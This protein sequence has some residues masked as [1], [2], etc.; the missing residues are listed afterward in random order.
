MK[1]R[2]SALFDTLTSMSLMNYI[3]TPQKDLKTEWPSYPVAFFALMVML[4]CIIPLVII[5]VWAVVYTSI[6]FP[7]MRIPPVRRRDYLV[8]DR[9]KLRKLA[10]IQRFGCLYCSYANGVTAW[11]KAVANMTEL[12]TCAIRHS[13]ERKGQE[14]QK[15]FYPYNKFQ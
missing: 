2:A 7:L 11:C 3:V 6:F 14:H 5:D 10:P 12:Y 1:G 9:A 4:T 13:L 8:F 15:D